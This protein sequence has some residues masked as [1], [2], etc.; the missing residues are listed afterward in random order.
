M[1]SPILET[2]ES[3]EEAEKKNKNVANQ[4]GKRKLDAGWLVTGNATAGESYSDSHRTEMNDENG[5][6]PLQGQTHRRLSS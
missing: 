4:A 5:D 3:E 1:L 6:I 2:M